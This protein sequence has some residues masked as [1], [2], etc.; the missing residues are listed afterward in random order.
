MAPPHLS[1]P[2]HTLPLFFPSRV[3]KP[4]WAS[5]RPSA[6]ALPRRVP[7]Q[8]P[9][10]RRLPLRRRR[11]MGSTTRRPSTTSGARCVSFFYFRVLLDGSPEFALSLTRRG[12]RRESRE[13]GASR[14]R[15]G[16]EST[17]ASEKRF[18]LC[19]SKKD[20][21]RS[22]GDST[23]SPRVSAPPLLFSLVP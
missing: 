13:G 19:F 20:L 11:A 5:C 17:R 9:R 12:E 6:A 21:L 8:L 23:R 15:W 14:A 22:G 1:P 7:P 18:R 3:A 2:T 4:S 16:R 10:S